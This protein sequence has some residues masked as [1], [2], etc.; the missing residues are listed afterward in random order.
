ME[1]ATL[2]LG[3]FQNVR[4]VYARKGKD[5]LVVIDDIS[6]DLTEGSLVSLLGP[7]GCGKTTLLKI[8]AGLDRA[9]SGLVEVRGQTVT[10]PHEDFA[11]V[12]QQP[13]LMP[14][15]DVLVACTKRKR[16]HGRTER[17]HRGIEDRLHWFATWTATRTAP[18]CA[19]P[20]A[21]AS[22]PACAT[23]SS[24]SCGWSEPP[25]SPP[26]SATTP[27]GPAVPTGDHEVLTDFAGVL[28]TY[29]KVTVFCEG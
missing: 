27:G 21:S 14:W 5:P 11:F 25:A 2:R 10:G 12:F 19:P 13:N 17:R 29:L 15:R 1:D 9:T 8:V 3:R 7:S 6:F 4:K 28:R 18:R 16:G 26:R 22:W 23:W 24:P 20:A